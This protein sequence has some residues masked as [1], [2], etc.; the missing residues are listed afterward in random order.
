MTTRQFWILIAGLTLPCL[1]QRTKFAV[2]RLVFYKTELRRKSGL[3]IHHGHWG[4][5]FATVSVVMLVSGI[6]N[7]LSIGLAGFGWGLMLDEVI[8]MLKMPSKDKNSND[9]DLEL[10]VYGKARNATV[11]L[12]GTIVA[13]A[14]LTFWMFH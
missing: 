4:L 11:V 13:L 3:N 7:T 5:I 1:Y 12:I 8:P 10:E 2:N 9:R 6:R 14:I